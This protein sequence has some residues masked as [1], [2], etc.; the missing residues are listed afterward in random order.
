MEIDTENPDPPLIELFT[1]TLNGVD[2][3]ALLSDQDDL[4][5]GEQQ[6]S[7]AE[8]HDLKDTLLN[9]IT[10]NS[11]ASEITAAGVFIVDDSIINSA[12]DM[13]GLLDQTSHH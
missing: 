12:F 1:N 2:L 10:F 5:F 8:L 7:G 4:L 9:D 6:E 11:N 13:S 3:S